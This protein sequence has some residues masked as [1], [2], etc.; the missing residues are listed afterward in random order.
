MCN[1]QSTSAPPTRH[2][3][4][5]GVSRSPAEEKR[6]KKGPGF[7]VKRHAARFLAHLLPLPCLVKRSGRLEEELGNLRNTDENLNYDE[8]KDVIPDES[9]SIEQRWLWYNHIPRPT[10][11]RTVSLPN[12]YKPATTSRLPS[13]IQRSPSSRSPA[14]DSSPR[15][16]ARDP[17]TITEINS[18]SFCTLVPLS[19]LDASPISRPSLCQTICSNFFCSI[20]ELQPLASVLQMARDAH[21]SWCDPCSLSE[22]LPAE[23]LHELVLRMYKGI[24]RCKNCIA[25]MRIVRNRGEKLAATD[26]GNAGEQANMSWIGSRWF[27][28][29]DDVD[30]EL[31]QRGFRNL[32]ALSWHLVELRGHLSNFVRRVKNSIRNNVRMRRETQ[33]R[34]KSGEGS[35]EFGSSFDGRN[36]EKDLPQ[37]EEN[38]EEHMEETVEENLEEDVEEA[39]EEGVEEGVKEGVEEGV[40]EDVEEVVDKDV[41]EVREEDT[42]EAVDEDEEEE[43]AT[44]VRYSPTRTPAVFES[45]V[46]RGKRP[47]ATIPCDTEELPSGSQ[48]EKEIDGM[49]RPTTR[50]E[51]GR[52]RL[53]E[54]WF[55][56]Y[57]D[58]SSIELE[59]K[60]N[61]VVG[62][63]RIDS[64][65]AGFVE[66]L[67]EDESAQ[68][69]QLE[70]KTADEK[71]DPD[72]CLDL[73]KESQP[74]ACNS[75]SPLDERRGEQPIPGTTTTISN[76]LP[77]KCTTLPS[78]ILDPIP[79]RVQV[80]H[81]GKC[82]ATDL[83]ASAQSLPSR[84]IQPE[85]VATCVSAIE[86]PQPRPQPSSIPVPAYPEPEKAR[87]TRAESDHKHSPSFI[88]KAHTSS[89]P[90]RI[91]P[92]P[93]TTR[94]SS[95]RPSSSKPSLPRPFS[96]ALNRVSHTFSTL[97]HTTHSPPSPPS[98]P[99][100][101]SP[102]LITRPATPH[103]HGKAPHST[104]PPVPPRLQ[105]R[106][107]THRPPPNLSHPSP[108]ASTAPLRRTSDI[109]ML[110]GE[111]KDLADQNA[112][113]GVGVRERERENGSLGRMVG[114][115]AV[116]GAGVARVGVGRTV[117]S[118]DVPSIR[119]LREVWPGEEYGDEDEGG[120]R[121][122]KDV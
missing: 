110:F 16:L 32:D 26:A 87:R 89:I 44:A 15:S 79:T 53:P 3:C 17:V 61:D 104:F 13:T 101:S 57:S 35:G 105:P 112:R 122:V 85:T 46:C 80:E 24:V 103:P 118:E 12:G 94:H 43:A 119:G 28:S 86:K 50:Q 37:E 58:T 41:E 14:R 62:R 52:A 67:G 33:V 19:V 60:S 117:R 5:L 8:F 29:W 75:L 39:V 64:V 42:E 84:S 91:Q 20:K 18:L 7:Q 65:I 69:A 120:A 22:T 88:P 97:R 40:K 48:S 4:S 59:G 11:Y 55:N 113:L 9:F 99:A 45:E 1:A 82:S 90:V 74:E 109:T 23:A 36:G 95:P 66:F 38:V 81:G 73:L 25:D 21:H 54:A 31:Q 116:R 98:S 92:A 63:Q 96:R 72:G 49:M 71:L 107:P 27:N 121:A 6:P 108:T 111:W 102:P 68:D 115:D 56:H 114:R 70:G 93:D 78:P 34:G 83:R 76:H 77:D 2:A 30:R 10:D 106:S 51:K 47:A 100:P